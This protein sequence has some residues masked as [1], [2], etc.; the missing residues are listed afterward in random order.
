MPLCLVAG[1]S[2]CQSVPQNHTG[3]DAAHTRGS[4]RAAGPNWTVAW[5]QLKLGMDPV[6][7]LSLLDEPRDVKITSANTSW[8]YSDRQAEGP[9]VVFGTREMRVERWRAPERR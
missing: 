3:V 6:Q 9:H 8:Y 7:V 4:A 5:S 1:I 2:A